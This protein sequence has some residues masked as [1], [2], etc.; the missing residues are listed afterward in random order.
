MRA[1]TGWDNSLFEILPASERS[2]V[3]SRLFNVREGL[4]AADDRVIDR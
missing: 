1:I 2:M 3:M 4:E